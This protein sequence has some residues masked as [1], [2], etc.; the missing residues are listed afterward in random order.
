MNM[1]FNHEPHEIHEKEII[2]SKFRVFRAF[3]GTFSDSY[4]VYLKF[5]LKL[6]LTH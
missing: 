5:E 4:P 1:I 6:H 3:R 2:K